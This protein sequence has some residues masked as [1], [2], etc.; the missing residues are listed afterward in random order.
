M[1]T[2]TL[3]ERSKKRVKKI[4]KIRATGA[5]DLAR[6]KKKGTATERFVRSRTANPKKKKSSKKK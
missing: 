2:H 3:K 1:P 4:N 6:T 5:K